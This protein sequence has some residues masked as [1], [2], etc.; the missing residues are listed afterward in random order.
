MG[1]STD[2]TL[3]VRGLQCTHSLFGIF[4]SVGVPYVHRYGRGARVRKQVPSHNILHD[5]SHHGHVLRG[6]NAAGIY[7]LPVG[8]TGHCMKKLRL[9]IYIDVIERLDSGSSIVHC[10][11]E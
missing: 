2:V 10:L 8:F 1:V 6:Y 7:V 3:T 5:C 11:N 9:F 4:A